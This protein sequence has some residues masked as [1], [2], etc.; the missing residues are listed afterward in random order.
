[1]SEE[2]KDAIKNNKSLIDYALFHKYT[3]QYNEKGI[4]TKS[5]KLAEIHG[6]KS[7][8]KILPYNKNNSRKDYNYIEYHDNIDTS[9]IQIDELVNAQIKPLL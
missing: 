4:L 5:G 2:I 6:D 1:M 7:V 9:K 3:K 8:Y